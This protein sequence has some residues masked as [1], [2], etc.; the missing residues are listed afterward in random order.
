MKEKESANFHA[1]HQNVKKTSLLRNCEL[2][3]YISQRVEVD[4][5]F[6]DLI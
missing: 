4:E 5:L 3:K 6:H 1:W 2:K